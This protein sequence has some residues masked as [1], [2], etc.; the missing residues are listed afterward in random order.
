MRKESFFVSAPGKVILF[1]EHAV[2]YSKTAIAGSLDLRAYSLVCPHDD[3]VL[4]LQLPDV[5][6]E[7][8]INTEQLP[9]VDV[10]AIDPI[11]VGQP[12]A[13][14]AAL[15]ATLIEHTQLP[16]HPQQ[17]AVVAFLYL[18]IL[19]AVQTNQWPGVTF[20]TRSTLPIGAGLGS[21]ASYCVC[22]AA[23]IR[24]LFELEQMPSVVHGN[25]SGV[26]NTVSCY[27]GALA[28]VGGK[29]SPLNAFQSLRFII[30]NTKVPRNTKVLVAGV[31]QRY[32]SMPT[33]I[34]PIL[35]SIHNISEAFKAI[36]AKGDHLLSLNN[37]SVNINTIT[38]Q[39]PDSFDDLKQLI[40]INHH[41]L[42]ALGVGHPALEDV[43]QVTQKHGLI[44]KLTGAGGGGCALTLVPDGKNADTPATTLASVQQLLADHGYECYETKVGGGGVA[45]ASPSTAHSLPSE[46][47]GFLTAPANILEAQ[48]GWL[49]Y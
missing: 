48:A 17:S 2:V 28:F 9:R 49:F 25:P 7:F 40:D 41:L 47:T 8:S 3:N 15:Q 38:E 33:V 4:C 30:T 18:Y 32:N 26:D 34:T 11:I 44:T 14:D 36:V 6:V 35:E 46:P 5:G 37:T 10:T 16:A 21:S 23:A 24:H 27:G 22:I 12:V 43:R 31:R 13:L 45:F 20:C 19:A 29:M 39:L 42:A 1:G